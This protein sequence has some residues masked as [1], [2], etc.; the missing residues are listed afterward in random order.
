MNIIF[1]VTKKFNTTQENKV[2]DTDFIRTN[3][4]GQ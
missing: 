1:C 2:T 4:Y 3:S